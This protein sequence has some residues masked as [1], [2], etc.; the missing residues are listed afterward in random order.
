MGNCTTDYLLIFRSRLFSR[1]HIGRYWDGTMSTHLVSLHRNP[2]Y[3]SSVP[4]ASILLVPISYGYSMELLFY[5]SRCP[6]DS[7]WIFPSIIKERECGYPSHQQIP[8]SCLRINSSHSRL[9]LLFVMWELTSQFSH[10]KWVSQGNYLLIPRP[11]VAA[12]TCW[13]SLKTIF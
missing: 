1:S 7:S 5:S 12:K 2:S 9:H 8:T 13:W 4:W 11:H 10:N 6:S 3:P